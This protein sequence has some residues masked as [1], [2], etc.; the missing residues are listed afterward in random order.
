M[1][2][3]LERSEHHLPRALSQCHDN[4]FCVEKHLSYQEKFVSSSN[5]LST[6]FLS[7]EL[8]LSFHNTEVPLHLL[9]KVQELLVLHVLNLGVPGLKKILSK[10]DNLNSSTSVL[11]PLLGEVCCLESINNFEQGSLLDFLLF[12]QAFLQ[13]VLEVDAHE[14][15]TVTG[16][17][18]IF[19]F[20][21][22]RVD[23]VITQL[24]PVWIAINYFFVRSESTIALLVKVLIPLVEVIEFSSDWKRLSSDVDG[25][26]DTKVPDL[27]QSEFWHPIVFSL[28]FVWLN[29][30][31]EVTLTRQQLIHQT[32]H[33]LSE[34]VPQELLKRV[35]DLLFNYFV[36]CNFLIEDFHD[37]CISLVD[38]FNQ[39]L[40]KFI[41]ILLYEALDVV[42]NILG[43]V[44][45]SENALLEL[46]DP[47]V[48]VTRVIFIDITQQFVVI[49][50]IVF[51]N[52]TDRIDKVEDT[53]RF[54]VH[55]IHDRLVISVLDQI[56]ER[57]QSFLGEDISL[58]FEDVRNVQVLQLFVGVVDT[59]LLDRVHLEIFETEDVQQTNAGILFLVF[60]KQRNIKFLDD[61]VEDVV[62][63][64]LG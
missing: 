39:I 17:N 33:F 46:R 24:F 3:S 41:L 36:V 28:S 49:L 44:L 6:V 32:L 43:S 63:K 60:W 16:Q 12:L 26:Q 22:Q 14:N 58:S 35:G 18:L 51:S 61:P 55:E 42:L 64:I 5:H 7:L 53:E 2:L 23:D 38:S 1:Q 29:T 37:F 4:F 8:L 19:L 31:H 13:I 47:K 40:R 54:L 15:S 50:S 11:V 56:N 45:D 52:L 59:K 34:F 57:S 62:E 27:S 21:W 48:L 25:V 9:D 30:S 20:L 10:G